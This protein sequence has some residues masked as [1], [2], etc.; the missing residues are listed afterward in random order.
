MRNVFASLFGADTRTCGWRLP[1]ASVLQADKP[2]KSEGEE[3]EQEHDTS[4]D[5]GGATGGTDRE[6][7]EEGDKVGVL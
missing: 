3:G 6:R 7:R 5:Y 4:P 2:D 1:T